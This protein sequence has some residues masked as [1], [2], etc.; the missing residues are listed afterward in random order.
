MTGTA[1]G[2]RFIVIDDGRAVAVT[3][4]VDAGRV[5]LSAAAI[6][7]ALGWELKPQGLCRGD[8]CVPLPPGASP[9]HRSLDLINLAEVLCRPLALDIEEGA[10]YLGA[11][12]E[13]RCATLASLDAPDFTLPDLAGRLHSLR[14]HRGRKVLLVAYASW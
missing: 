1:E 4:H 11:P 7:A 12:V 6:E 2:P 5:W 14:E 9:D 10:A 8:E 3:A 13:E